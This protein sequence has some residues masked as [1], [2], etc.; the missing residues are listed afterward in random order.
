MKELQTPD[1]CKPAL[2][3]NGGGYFIKTKLNSRGDKGKKISVVSDTTANENISG[4]VK[5]IQPFSYCDSRCFVFLSLVFLLSLKC[6]CPNRE[7]VARK[8]NW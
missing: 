7:P 2:P 8:K 4:V 1:T 3:M 5:V 6:F